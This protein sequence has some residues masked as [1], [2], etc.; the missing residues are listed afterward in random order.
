MNVDSRKRT[1][2]NLTF[3]QNQFAVYNVIK[4]FAELC[5]YSFMCMCT[6]MYGHFVIYRYSMVDFVL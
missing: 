1:I 3:V 4:V 2:Y 5:R 6:C